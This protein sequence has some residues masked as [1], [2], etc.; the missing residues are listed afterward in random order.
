[1]GQVSLLFPLFSLL[2]PISISQPPMRLFKF[3]IGASIIATAFGFPAAQRTER[4]DSDEAILEID[5]DLSALKPDQ[6]PFY[7]PPDG[8]ESAAPGDILRSRQVTTSFLGI[9]P[10]NLQ[11]SYQL[12]YRTVDHQQ[13]PSATVLT[14]LVPHH[15]KEF[16][17]IVSFQNAEDSGELTLFSLG[18]FVALWLTRHP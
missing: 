13:Q 9:L 7:K 8:Y 17:E 18:S 6:D 16:P 4:S 5:V 10:E 15:A 12:L 2:S 1:M 11:A 14:V 3:L